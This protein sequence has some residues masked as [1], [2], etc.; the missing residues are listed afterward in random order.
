MASGRP[1][2]GGDIPIPEKAVLRW[3]MIGQRVAYH[4]AEKRKSDGR[5]DSS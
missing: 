4:A 2:N 3:L 5:G 1:P